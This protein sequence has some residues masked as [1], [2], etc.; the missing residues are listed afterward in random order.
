MPTAR[1]SCTPAP[2]ADVSTSTLGALLSVLAV[3]YVLA[4][5]GV[6]VFGLIKTTGRT[7]NL[8]LGGV[9]ALILSRFIGMFMPLIF[10][11]LSSSAD[12]FMAMTVV[13][14]LVGSAVSV[15]GVALLVWAAVTAGSGVGRNQGYPEPQNP[16]QLNYPAQGYNG[17][18]SYQ[19]PQ[20]Y[21]EPQ[22]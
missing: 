13:V 9:G 7:R 21:N 3:V 20:G 2:V 5:V 11:A 1:P 6:G 15:G 10:G 14:N 22:R 4:L 19:Q 12:T 18:Q 17:L 8:V 16:Y